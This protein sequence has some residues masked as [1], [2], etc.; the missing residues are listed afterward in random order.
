MFFGVNSNS[1]S[2]SQ[3][4]KL[5]TVRV[6]LL[7][8][9]L[10]FLSVHTVLAGTETYVST[11]G[12]SN[13]DGIVSSP[14]DIAFDSSGNM[15]VS[16]TGNNRIQKF[17]SSGNYLLQ[18]GSYGP[19]D[20]QFGSPDGIAVDSA[21]NIYV[22]DKYNNRIQKFTSAG[23][24]LA[25][26][27]VPGYP[28]GLAIDQSDNS[29]YVSMSSSANRIYKYDGVGNSIL[30]WGG[31]G[32]TDGLFSYAAGVFVDSAGDVYV[33]DRYNNRIQKFD[34]SGNYLLQATGVWYP[35]DVVV[36]SAGYIF[37]TDPRFNVIKKYA[38][39]GAF[40]EDYGSEGSADGQFSLPYGLA[41]DASD[42]LYVADNLNSR[43]QKFTNAGVFVSQIG[44]GRFNYPG[45][46]VTDS[47]GNVYI[48][49][50]YNHRI[51]KYDSNGQLLFTLGTSG[52]GEG[53]FR[54]PGGVAVDSSGNIYVS[55]SGN[56]RIQKFSPA[57]AFILQ[58]GQAGS[59]IG[60][61]SDP[62]QIT[63]DAS[64]NLYVADANNYRIQKFDP[65]GTP[66]LQFGSYGS[67]DEQF[68]GAL[69]AVAV[70][71]LGNIY[72]ANDSEGS[73]ATYI[74]KFNSSGVFI[75]KWGVYGVESLGFSGLGSLAVDSSDQVY[76]T[77]TSAIRVLKYTSDGIFLSQIGELGEAFN[78]LGGISGVV[79]DLND[80]IYVSDYQYSRIQK[81]AY[82]SASSLP[83][84]FIKNY[85]LDV[86]G[87]T[88]AIDVNVASDGGE[89]ITERGIVYS[90][91][92]TVPTILDSVQ[93]ES[94]TTGEYT[95]VL[96]GLT[97][98]SYY[99]VRAYA[100]NSI[101]TEYGD[102]VTFFM[103]NRP[104]VTTG[105]A[106][107]VAHDGATV[108]GNVTADGGSP[109]VERGIVYSEYSAIP[110][111]DT[112]SYVTTAGTTGEFSVA[113]EYIYPETQYYARAY[114][115]N[116]GYIAYGDVI[117]FT[118]PAY[119]APS[120]VTDTPA[121]HLSPTTATISGAIVSDG[122]SI[123]QETGIVYSSVNVV[124]DTN[125]DDY[126]S[127][128]T[129]GIGSFS[130][131]LINLTPE[132]EYY[133]R[134]FAVDSVGTYY[135]DVITFT[136]P[137]TSTPAVIT[138]PATDVSYTT[139]TLQGAIVDDGALALTEHGFV[140]SA[141]EAVPTL[142]NADVYGTING[143]VGDKQVNAT[144]LFPA[145]QYYYRIF[146]QNSAG[147][148]YGN[149]V[150]FTT[151]TPSATPNIQVD[152]SADFESDG[153]SFDAN[154]ADGSFSY[155]SEAF[156]ADT[157]PATITV[158]GV[159]FTTGPTA[160]G[161]NNMVRAFG[162]NIALPTA[163]A[164]SIQFLAAE[165]WEDITGMTFIAHYADTTSTAVD[166]SIS[167]WI[168]ENP[169]YGETVAYSQNYVN[170]PIGPDSA[171]HPKLYLYTIPLDN[172]KVL[173]SLEIPN[174]DGDIRIAAITLVDAVEVT[175]AAPTVVTGTATN[176]S[177][178][179]VS[180]SGDVTADGGA[181]ITERGIV[182]S[183]VSGVPTTADSVQTNAG[184]VGVFMASIEGLTSNTMYYFRAYA[185]N[186]QGTSYGDVVSFTT[187]SVTSPTVTT[188]SPAT[189]VSYTTATVT[190]D[191][192]SDGGDPIT[193]RGVVYSTT[194]NPP[195]TDD[196]K[197]IVDGT[198]GTFDANLTGLTVSTEY[199]ARAYAINPQGTSYGDVV[200]FTT[201]TPT[202]P[203]IT[204]TDPAVSVTATTATIG[205]D[206]VSDNGSSITERGVVYSTTVN[207][208]TIDDLKLTVAGTTGNFSAVLTGL[209]MSTAYFVRAYA[210]NAEGTAY[211]DVV[212]FTTLSAVAPTVSTTSPATSI[213]VTAAT[214]SGVVSSDGGAEIT[215]R[216][217]VYSST[218]NTPTLETRVMVTGTTGAISQSLTGLVA[219][220]TYY[221]RVYA[222]NSEGTTYGN[223]ITFKTLTAIPTT[224]KNVYFTFGKLR[225]GRYAAPS[226]MRSG[227]YIYLKNYDPKKVKLL[228]ISLYDYN[229][230]GNQ[231]YS[232]TW[233][234]STHMYMKTC[235]LLPTKRKYAF[236]FTFQDIAT[237]TIIKK[238]FVVNTISSSTITY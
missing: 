34:S 12:G 114:A 109:I 14:Y 187:L 105:G 157:F 35:T 173:S 73:E 48:V 92:N 40:V 175:V 214:V 154:P 128:S 184:T 68:D 213:A 180:L 218:N 19:A 186:S 84:T 140:I 10:L 169:S 54:Y 234:S 153:I 207:P 15:Y 222:T 75:A 67:G 200:I 143:T 37:A 38:P 134:A 52:T 182:Y 197:L 135:G 191:V 90:D 49:D 204:T 57:G 17:D 71:S 205:G 199:F 72:A 162:Q 113:L 178:T 4:V 13:L 160:D 88:A 126:V 47:S 63:V 60:Q 1:A 56:N 39:N 123:M 116:D 79:V 231:C 142:D 5:A 171:K 230:K 210:I 238:Y 170:T 28:G 69:R 58:W 24:F 104:T 179:T 74:K 232:R 51:A 82:N 139:A 21:D 81:F 177:Y 161:A 196:I 44:K 224:L 85:T 190:G 108:S 3:R 20:G 22:A 29:V 167:Y 137:L 202:M 2:V 188:T 138:G 217:I 141:I 61:F 206:V 225:Y 16:D 31:S 223:V 65:S 76:V 203:T 33:A 174:Y 96:S 227:D 45:N 25:K 26:W 156:S 41:L 221:A 158:G 194:V 130:V 101:G 95:T 64:D 11:I 147:I 209:P 215:E 86:A 80:N 192:S 124:P 145:T 165:A 27:T 122:S 172:T 176:V 131:T 32:D 228:A 229:I 212:S 50:I 23:A 93:S 144:E 120:A 146:A 100:I 166:M 148:S 152:L 226:Q 127:T 110:D 43:I 237:R 132:T 98:G 112:D 133:A 107:L 83:V 70:D 129:P 118:T 66:L 136:T 77:D 181:D 125:N 189:N 119:V 195:T 159:D 89:A 164:A 7:A 121:S 87:S 117:T 155:D 219:N 9:T 183:D 8:M 233:K 111:Y 216:G 150:T 236:I 62:S 97:V 115:W 106:T 53:Q 211:G 18:W 185:I 149:S 168:N 91:S 42:N 208:P 163:R 193:E 220:T 36:D 201:A 99:H 103:A 198:T 78:Q 55:D 6:V 94:G 151:L 235:G 30:D 102:V 59:D 46:L